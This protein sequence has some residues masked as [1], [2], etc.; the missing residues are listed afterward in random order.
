M[1]LTEA[2]QMLARQMGAEGN[3]D[4]TI[5]AYT[6]DVRHFVGFLNSIKARDAVPHFTRDN[7]ERWCI[8]QTEKGIAPRTR[9][10]RF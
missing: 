10:R 5:Q 8:E 1:T 4:A 2:M 9:N 7:V 3:S 6:T